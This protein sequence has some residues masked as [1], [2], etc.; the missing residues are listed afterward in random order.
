MIKRDQFAFLSFIASTKAR[1]GGDGRPGR[2]FISGWNCD[3]KK[4]GCSVIS[5]ISI[6]SPLVPEK[7]MPFSLSLIHISEPTRPY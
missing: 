1:N 3:A 7:T 2:D 4:K 5:Q 6:K